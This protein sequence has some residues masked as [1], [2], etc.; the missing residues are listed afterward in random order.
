[1]ALIVGK[2]RLFHIDKFR[3]KVVELPE[4]LFGSGKV[5]M[6]MINNF[7]DVS[8]SSS[9]VEVILRPFSP[10]QSNVV[11]LKVSVINGGWLQD[12]TVTVFVFF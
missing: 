7:I 8:E 4:T 3:H 10:F 2:I 12:Q 1:L 9:K 11:K 6:F 5:G